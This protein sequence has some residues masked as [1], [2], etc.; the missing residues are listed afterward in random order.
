MGMAARL[1]KRGGK[2]LPQ[3]GEGGPLA[4]PTTRAGTDQN[5]G[6]KKRRTGMRI[7][8]ALIEDARAMHTVNARAYD[9]YEVLL[10]YLPPP[11]R[12]DPADWIEADQAWVGERDSMVMAILVAHSAPGHL[13]VHSAVVDPDWQGEGHGRAL[14]SHAEVLAREAGLGEVRLSANILMDRTIS[15]YRHCGF[16]IA[17]QRPHPGQPSQVLADMVKTV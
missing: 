10:G 7:R 13:I 16:K 15:L 11:A 12:E 17:G 4:Q 3:W 2:P 5:A 8:R 1:G 14:L 9:V 6:H